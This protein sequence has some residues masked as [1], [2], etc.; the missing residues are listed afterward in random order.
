[1]ADPAAGA[2]PRALSA[3]DRRRGIR[4]R[5]E[6]AVR[7]A[8]HRQHRRRAQA[9]AARAPRIDLGSVRAL[10]RQSA[11]AADVH[12]DGHGVHRCDRER[13]AARQNAHVAP[14]TS[15][16]L[17]ARHRLRGDAHDRRHLHAHRHRS[18]RA[19]DFDVQPVAGD[20]AAAARAHLVR[21]G[22]R[23]HRVRDHPFGAVGGRAQRALG[24]SRRFRTR[25]GWWAATTGSP[26]FATSARSSFRRRSRASSPGSRWAGRS[27]GAR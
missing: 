5:R 7:L 25:C 17:R 26:A 24:L 4:H 18:P 21:I 27:R 11:A 6:A 14:D 10:A 3:G 1:M 2:T 22:L 16:R 12:V 15:R 23:Q 8:A 20:R 9:R 19:A 13:R